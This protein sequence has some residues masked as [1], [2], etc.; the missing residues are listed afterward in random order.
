MRSAHVDPAAVDASAVGFRLAPRINAAGRLG[1]PD[2]A[3]EL[4]LT[5]DAEEA[6]EAGLRARGAEPRPPG[7]RGPDPARGRRARRGAARGR[8]PPARLRPLARG[9]ARGRDRHRGLSPGGAVH[10]PVVLITRSHDGWK[11]SG[12][13][14]SR[15]DLHGAL[16]ACSAHLER[17]GGHRAAA[18]LSIE[19]TSIEAFADGLRRPRGRDSRR[20]GPPPGD[21]VSM[22]SS[23]RRSSRFRSRRSSTGSHRSGSE[24]PT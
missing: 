19:E 3:L 4:I 2:A 8:A 11:G 1:R 10:R 22:P 21:T 23:R 13:S 6:T 14:V 24:T 9:L 20:R 12:R 16:A 17:F 18:G 5:E 15:F 7:G